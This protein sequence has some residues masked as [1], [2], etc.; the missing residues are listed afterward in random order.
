M[1]PSFL[2][3]LFTI[4][5]AV[6][7]LSRTL[8][9]F[10]SIFCSL[11]ANGQVYCFGDNTH[12]ALGDGTTQSSSV[13]VKMREIV[14]ASDVSVGQDY[15]CVVDSDQV[16]CLGLNIN[17]RLGDG[18]S[19]E[20]HLLVRTNATNARQV[21]CG[22]Y[23]TCALLHGN[24]LACW[25]SGSHGQLGDGAQ[26]ERPYPTLISTVS[27]VEFVSLGFIHTCIVANGGR[28]YCTGNNENAQLGNVHNLTNVQTF[29]PVAKLPTDNK[30]ISVASS[31]F[32]VCA[33]TEQGNVWCW[34]S[35]EY[36]QLGRKALVEMYDLYIY[37]P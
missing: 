28:V 10:S 11:Q 35:N 17:Y 12:G 23:H 8:A 20:R 21:F 37:T 32:H 30:F 13:P 5:Q 3:L 14:S 1:K 2:V 7:V 9:G 27:N 22:H 19:T 4:V 24:E 16:K 6:V 26:V 18:T 29:T 33:V 31:G 15:A 34:G 25:G 36:G